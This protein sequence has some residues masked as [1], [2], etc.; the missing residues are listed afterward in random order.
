[1]LSSH[2]GLISQRE[3]AG[4]GEG[5]GLSDA[6][7][8][9]S[10]QPGQGQ[11]E[12]RPLDERQRLPPRLP[13]VPR[14]IRRR[15][16][17]Q[18]HLPGS[19]PQ[20]QIVRLNGIS[21][22]VITGHAP[23]VAVGTHQPDER[24]Q[25][26][27]RRQQEHGELGRHRQ[28]QR[29]TG[30][31]IVPPP[32]PACDLHDEPERERHER[33]Q[34]AVYDKEM[35]LLNVHD[36]DRQERRR[37]QT[38][39]TVVQRGPDAIR[40]YDGGEVEQHAHHTS[41]QMHLVIGI[42]PQPLR[43]VPH[44]EDRKGAVDEE[45]VSLVVGVQR[46]LCGIEVRADGAGQLQGVL[47]HRQK[48]LVRVEVVPV[49]PVQA[50]ESEVGG[51]QQ[52]DEQRRTGGPGMVRKTKAPATWRRRHVRR[53]YYRPVIPHDELFQRAVRLRC[54]PDRGRCRPRR[55]STIDHAQGG[56]R[57]SLGAIM[58]VANLIG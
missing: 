41:Q 16:G 49:V 24:A 13:L 55:R 15:I 28:P 43:Q 45:A 20:T 4:A 39:P 26:H 51:D 23:P 19:T 6:E 38:D 8:H 29:E 52:N 46:G 1:M 2:S 56:Q 12:H 10:D 50:G 48:A 54:R 44:Q 30:P 32:A 35:G 42:A 36:R 17:R 57:A 9:H 22:G 7:D 14:S 11:A 37:Q 21:G 40:Q 5:I 58:K 31:H 27:D 53:L 18:R 34:I 33:H 3:D 47:H 25:A